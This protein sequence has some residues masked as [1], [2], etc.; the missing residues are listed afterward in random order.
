MKTCKSC[1]HS[2]STFDHEY[3]P[4]LMCGVKKRD[5]HIAIE[6]CEEYERE[7]GCDEDN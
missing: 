1:H 2:F 7:V 4:I 6:V 3:H 5:A